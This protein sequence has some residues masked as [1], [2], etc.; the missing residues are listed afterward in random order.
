MYETHQL[1]RN[2]GIDTSSAAQPDE[3]SWSSIS[4]NLLLAELRRRQEDGEKPEC[5]SRERGWYDTAAHVF[6]L[7]LILALS[8][9]SM[10]FYHSIK[11]PIGRD[12]L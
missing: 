8:T 4:T 5:G 12:I 9:L 1:S 6:A 10:R 7:F 2:T 3:A 11:M